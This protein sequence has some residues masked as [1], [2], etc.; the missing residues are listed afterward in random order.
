VSLISGAIHHV[1]YLVALPFQAAADVPWFRGVGP[2]GTTDRGG[3]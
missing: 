1:G 3:A 2:V